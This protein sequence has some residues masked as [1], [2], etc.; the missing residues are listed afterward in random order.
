ML[1]SKATVKRFGVGCAG[2]I[3]RSNSCGVVYY[4]C[5]SGRSC[6][7]PGERWY[8]F[9]WHLDMTFWVSLSSCYTL[10]Q[11]MVEYLSIFNLVGWNILPFAR[12]Y[13]LLVEIA[14]HLDI[15]VSCFFYIS[16]YHLTLIS[17]T[18]HCTSLW[19]LKYQKC[20]QGVTI[21]PSICFWYHSLPR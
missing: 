14:F 1:C 15:D 8:V 7:S 11:L 5:L 19:G 9:P 6:L 3:V 17:P 20:P 18:L 12:W 21:F 2:R 13:H 16:C 4:A 10:I